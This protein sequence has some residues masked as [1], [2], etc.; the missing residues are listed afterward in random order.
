[1]NEHRVISHRGNLSGP[2]KDKENQP[3]EID[4]AIEFGF[5]VEV[6]VWNVNQKL[7][8]GHDKPETPVS[9][10][11]LYERREFLWV[12]CKNSEAIASLMGSDLN[13]FFHDKDLHALT[14]KGFLW[15]R[16]GYYRYCSEEILVMPERLFDFQ[17]SSWFTKELDFYG[18]CTD[19]PL[20]FLQS[21]ASV[22]L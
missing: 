5:D 20:D 9:L 10:D 12:H 8:L 6:D 16:P 19:Y 18:V 22:S 1:M 14:S 21:W 11:F 15:S 4:K 13:F 2:S 7:F 3:L 17:G